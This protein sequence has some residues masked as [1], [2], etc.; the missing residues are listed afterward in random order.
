MQVCANTINKEDRDIYRMFASEKNL[1][2]DIVQHYVIKRLRLCVRYRI[3]SM[4][5]PQMSQ[6]CAKCRAI[7]ILYNIV[8]LKVC[9]YVAETTLR[10]RC[11]IGV[12]LN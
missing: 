7:S 5:G 10:Q 3:C 6:L 11:A 9:N 4:C 2:N 12:G 1:C 8:L